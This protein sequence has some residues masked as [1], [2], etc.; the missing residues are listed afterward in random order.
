MDKF[1]SQLN[2]LIAIYLCKIK[3]K[4]DCYLKF[5]T[6]RIIPSL[7]V[8][9]VFSQWITKYHYNPF[10]NSVETALFTFSN[11]R[12]VKLKV[13]LLIVVKIDFNRKTTRESFFKSNL[14]FYYMSDVYPHLQKSNPNA[15]NEISY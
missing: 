14:L 8:I 15:K 12:K 7:I 11:M 5:P 4:D 6:F 1:D 10:F 2:Q 3:T 13:H 9:Y